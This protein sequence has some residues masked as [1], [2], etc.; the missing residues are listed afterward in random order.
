MKKASLSMLLVLVCFFVFTASISAGNGKIKDFDVLPN[1]KVIV[2]NS[3]EFK[4][5]NAYINSRFFKENGARCLIK[6]SPLAQLSSVGGDAFLEAIPSD[7]SLSATVIQ[8]EYWP[9]EIYVVPIVFHI[10]HKNDGT[11]NIPDSR[12]YNQV[13]I[14]NEDYRAI[15]GTLGQQGFDVHLQFELAGITRTAND[16]WFRDRGQESAY[17]TALAWDVN[18]YLNIYVNSASGYLGYAY[19]PQDS[20]GE[21]WDGITLLY[22]ACGGRDEGSAPYD[23]G[24]TL[25]HEAGHYLGL[26]H[27][28]D[29][30]CGEGYTAGDLIADTESE[31]T[32]HY[33]CVQTTTCNT[34][35]PIHNY[36]NYTDDLCMYEFTPEQGNRIICSLVNY[37]PNLYYFDGGGVQLAD[38][39]VNGIS[40]TTTKKGPNWKANATITILDTDSSPVANATVTVQWSGAVSG[41]ASGVT[42][43]DGT[44][45]ITSPS[46]KS[47]GVTFTVTVTDVTATN[48]TYDSSLNVETS[49]SISN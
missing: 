40:M 28:F 8:N 1:G 48:R 22:S 39:F 21:W 26:L 15:A 49:G 43:A 16:Q 2:N 24:R 36:M 11:G 6:R 3:V 45:T 10:I 25:V 35:D 29:G 38:M 47:T 37:R 9:T 17:K 18:S 20:A 32:A 27:T 31:S 23:Q 42:A 12:I 13:Q 7:C 34:P 4:N 14:L 5:M 30:G 33:D 46:T 19:M 44:V 41:S